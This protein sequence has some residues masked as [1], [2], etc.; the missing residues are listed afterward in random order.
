LAAVKAELQ[1]KPVLLK[2]RIAS[3]FDECCAEDFKEMI[4]SENPI[5]ISRRTCKGFCS[6]D[7][8]CRDERGLTA[9]SIRPK[10]G[11]AMLGLV[12]Q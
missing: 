5:G 11:H 10:P 2:V 3:K 6:N 1:P 8:R 9:A 12:L 7:A 4:S